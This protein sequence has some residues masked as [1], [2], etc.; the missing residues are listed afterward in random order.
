[1]RNMKQDM[2]FLVNNIFYS[3]NKGDVL[4]GKIAPASY[5]S[6]DP[7]DLNPLILKTSADA[8]DANRVDRIVKHLID[9][10]KYT[11]K[12]HNKNL[13]DTNNQAQITRLIMSEFSLFTK[14][15][16]L[17]IQDYKE[18]IGQ[19]RTE[20]NNGN[21]PAD[22]HLVAA[23]LPVLF[24][25]NTVHNSVLYLRSPI[26]D[27][28]GAKIHHFAKNSFSASD[29]KYDGYELG[30]DN[31]SADKS[32]P[33]KQIGV[34]GEQRIDIM[35][36]Y[37]SAIMYQTSFGAKAIVTH[38]ICADHIF[39]SANNNLTVLLQF[40]PQLNTEIPLNVEHIITANSLAKHRPKNLAATV[41][42]CDH[43]S[44][45][46]MIG[47]ES[48]KMKILEEQFNQNPIFGGSGQ[49]ASIYEAKPIG[50]LS[51][52]H[53]EYFISTTKAKGEDALSSTLNAINPV[54]QTFIHRLL[55]EKGH[56][57]DI[58]VNR[59]IILL[60][61]GIINLDIRDKNGVSV[62]EQI[63]SSGNQQLIEEMKRQYPQHFI[64]KSNINQTTNKS[65]I[66][67]IDSNNV[68]NDTL[69]Q[70]SSFHDLIKQGGQSKTV[71][72]T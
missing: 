51:N 40:L 46:S 9:L 30:P 20:L 49:R 50:I 45:R 31:H 64:D 25:D 59:I 71:F 55:Q 11:S 27:A 5:Y 19:L 48:N 13:A 61:T 3:G 35:H 14:S 28:S 44:T 37:N 1:M 18:I 69:K 8:L 60:K 33:S 67:S 22:V 52:Q 58:N 16:P 39:N 68:K 21:Y 6:G 66:F 54:G 36:Q 15:T 42:H 72:N 32:S 29:Y 24:P 41:L 2:P 10:F 43:F 23:S 47:S 7:A 65:L 4:H 53:L 57:P 70:E 62:A 26:G 63:F 17:S 12:Q 56:D 38:D 34:T